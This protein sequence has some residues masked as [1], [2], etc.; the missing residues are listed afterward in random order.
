MSKTKIAFLDHPFHRKTRSSHFFAEMLGDEFEV[1]T[2]YVEDDPRAI[3]QEIG[4]SD[5]DIIVCW[6]TEVCAPY[7][8]M[9]GKRVICIP[10]YDSVAYAPD[11]YWLAMRQARFISFSKKLHDRLKKL[12]VE[13]F[14]FQYFGNRHE[15]VPRAKFNELRGFFWQRLPEEGLD[16]VW[17]RKLLGNVVSSLHIH[18]APD[19]GAPEDWRPDSLCTVTPF[20]EDGSDYLDALGQANVYVC[21]RRSEGI[22]MAMLEAMARGMCVIA[23]DEPTA[24]EYI[25]HKVNGLLIDYGN[26]PLLVSEEDDDV[27]RICRVDDGSDRRI[28]LTPEL[29]SRLGEQAYR[30]SINGAQRWAEDS[31]TIPFLIHAAPQA[32]LSDRE[33]EFADAYLQIAQYGRRDFG[34]FL[35][36][37]LRLHRRGLL[38]YEL[39]ALSLGEAIR[40]RLRAIPGLGMAYRFARRVY[41][42]ARRVYWR[43]FR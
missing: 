23:H 32:D 10:M 2:F 29:A 12:G 11:W 28:R 33:R 18:N 39:S 34:R 3:M 41:R 25:V 30:S 8:L 24:N 40:L 31:K 9:R 27:G 36:K 22:G 7:L 6:Q 15:N 21:P 42:F 35:H 26:P 38:G 16:Y 4:D 43:L 13:S 19:F 17:A 14:Y 37:L 5:Y 20:S 1:H